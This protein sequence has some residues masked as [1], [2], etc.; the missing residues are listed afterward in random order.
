[1]TL[2]KAVDF[3]GEAIRHTESV[4]K[5]TKIAAVDGGTNPGFDVASGTGDEIG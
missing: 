2:R 3:Q 4:A 5:S 1:M